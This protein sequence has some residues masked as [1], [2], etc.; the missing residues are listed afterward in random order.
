MEKLRDKETVKSK[1]KNDFIKRSFN[2]SCKRCCTPI[3]VNAFK[4][5]NDYNET[6]KIFTSLDKKLYKNGRS[7]SPK[8]LTQYLKR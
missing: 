8:E 4:V 1:I 7:I 2:Y 5:L 6:L 3:S